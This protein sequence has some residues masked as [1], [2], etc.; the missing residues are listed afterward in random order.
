MVIMVYV[1]AGFNARL[2]QSNLHKDKFKTHK[3]SQTRIGKCRGIERGF[4]FKALD[5]QWRRGL[6]RGCQRIQSVVVQADG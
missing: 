3:A 6:T 5:I 2:L 4:G 1:Q